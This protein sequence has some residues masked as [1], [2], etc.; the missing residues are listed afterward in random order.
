MFGATFV[1]PMSSGNVTLVKINQDGYSSEYR[2]RDS[3]KS[4]F[5][6]IR[7]SKTKAKDG[8]M[9]DRH[10]VEIVCT[11]FAT[12]AN[13]EYYQKAYF[14]MEM[15]PSDTSVDLFDALAEWAISPTNANLVSLANWES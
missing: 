8:K 5:A 12:E 15:L 9:Y 4:Y 6:K 13:P 3:T 1:L 10:N 11:I 7:H 2:F 14:V